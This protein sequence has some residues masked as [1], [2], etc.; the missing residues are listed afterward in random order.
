MLK[1]V[2]QGERFS[3]HGN[4]KDGYPEIIIYDGQGEGNGSMMFSIQHFHSCEVN[5]ME[6]TTEL[7]FENKTCLRISGSVVMLRRMNTFDV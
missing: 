3:G 1:P 5:I 6:N 2:T 4:E 7:W